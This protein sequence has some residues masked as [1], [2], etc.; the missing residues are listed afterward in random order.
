MNNRHPIILYPPDMDEYRGNPPYFTPYYLNQLLE[1]N[2]NQVN[3]RVISHIRYL[4]PNEPTFNRIL[5]N[6]P[7]VREILEQHGAAGQ[8]P[9]VAARNPNMVFQGPAP[10]DLGQYQF[11]EDIPDETPQEPHI[12]FRNDQYMNAPRGPTGAALRKPRVKKTKT[13][14]KK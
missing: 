5:V 3:G 9:Y 8:M 14:T 2:N 4:H 11:D 7:W 10:N 13:K 6:K 1:A 12:D